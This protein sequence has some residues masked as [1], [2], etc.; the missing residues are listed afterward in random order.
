MIKV[1]KVTAPYAT[2]TRMHMP[3]TPWA[4]RVQENLSRMGYAVWTTDQ[5]AEPDTRDA[6][7]LARA[8]K[9]L[10]LAAPY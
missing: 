10:A 6:A 9:L 4:F 8:S 7:E 2:D 3:C 1:I 5:V